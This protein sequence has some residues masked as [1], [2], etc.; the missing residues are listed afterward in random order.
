MRTAAQTSNGRQ[1]VDYDIICNI[2][3]IANC[4][5]RWN[6][7]LCVPAG[8][9]GERQRAER[10]CVRAVAERSTN[11]RQDVDYNIIEYEIFSSTRAQLQNRAFLG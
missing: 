4:S 8:A 3:S 2:S 5:L 11:G 7:K 6:R 10:D 9:D 1:E